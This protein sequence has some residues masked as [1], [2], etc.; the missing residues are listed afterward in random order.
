MEMEEN[1][2]PI[3]QSLGGLHHAHIVYF[4][5][6]VL[7]PPPSACPQSSLYTALHRII[8]HLVEGEK[9]KRANDI[10]NHSQVSIVIHKSKSK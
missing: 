10:K 7:C 6:V 3:L 5:S 2:G 4:C 1:Q 8:C 9:D